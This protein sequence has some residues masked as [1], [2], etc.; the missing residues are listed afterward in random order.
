MTHGSGKNHT[1]NPDFMYKIETLSNIINKCEDEDIHWV[2][3]TE[4]L[5]QN[6]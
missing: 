4:N 3:N 2:Y 6:G 5:R 1:N